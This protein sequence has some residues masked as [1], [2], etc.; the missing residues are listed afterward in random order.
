M[1]SLPRVSIKFEKFRLSMHGAVVLR[2]CNYIPKKLYGLDTSSLMM[3]W[4]IFFCPLV[5]IANLCFKKWWFHF[6]FP[7][8]FPKI[9]LI[10]R[11]KKCTPQSII[12]KNNVHIC[13]NML[14][15]TFLAILC[16]S[17]NGIVDL[18]NYRPFQR[19]LKYF[20]II[21]LKLSVPN[22]IE[23]LIFST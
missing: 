9:V 17:K 22:S 18:E 12:Q 8:L 1:K 6:I 16:L 13:P 19:V 7:F 20:W 5:F 14:I 4:T 10:S 21:I 3:H 23:N 11:H 2:R 15:N